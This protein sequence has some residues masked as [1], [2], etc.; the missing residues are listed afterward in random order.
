VDL[1]SLAVELIDRLPA[2]RTLGLTVVEAVDGIGRVEM[3]VSDGVR[4]VI[5]ALH[6]SGVAALA[7]AASLAAAL[8]V[9][10]G[11]A[12][13]RRLQP[14]GVGARLTFQRPVRGTAFAVCH[15]D[16]AAK[17]AL[18]ALIEGSEA[19]ARFRTI[20][21]IDGE[22]APGAAAGEFEWVVRLAPS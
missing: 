12:A 7:D 14:L 19:R 6:S 4:N 10:P 16:A 20:T 15:L 1:T 13:A 3:P 2:N 8:S 17:A 21:S 22:G 11:E 18:S 5:G 9:A